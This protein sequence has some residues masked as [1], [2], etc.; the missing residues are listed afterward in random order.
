MTVNAGRKM[1]SGAFVH[2]TG[3]HVAA[4]R[5]P[6]GHAASGTSFAQAVEAAQTAERGKFDL[7]FLAE[8]A[9]VSL[10]GP[11]QG[12]AWAKSAKFEPMTLLLALPTASMS[13]QRGCRG[14][15]TTSSKW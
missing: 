2:E 6:V 5:H 4:W 3:Q 14:R 8:S 1:I 9:A 15:S 11:E 10:R 7:L 13:C 12:A